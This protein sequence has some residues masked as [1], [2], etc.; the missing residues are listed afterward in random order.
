VAVH[1]AARP[2]VTPALITRIWEAARPVGAAV[3]GV[4]PADTVKRVVG[5]VV[6]A[7][8]PR[9]ELVLVQTPQIFRTELLRAA[10]DRGGGPVTD[11]SAWLEA[12]GLPVAVAAGDPE[13]R[14]VTEPADWEW[15]LRR[16]QGGDP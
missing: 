4:P 14:K 13:N 16:S 15:L 11:D 8:V 1:D 3:P 2:L 12:A 6:A 10:A 9:D 7:T 5:G